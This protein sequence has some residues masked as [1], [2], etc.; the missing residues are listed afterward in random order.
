MLKINDYFWGWKEREHSLKEPHLSGP[1]NCVKRETAF[2]QMFRFLSITFDGLKFDNLRWL[3]SFLTAVLFGCCCLFR[4]I[5]VHNHENETTH[6]MRRNEKTNNK[7]KHM[8]PYY[9]LIHSHNRNIKYPQVS[10]PLH[11]DKRYSGLPSDICADHEYSQIML[12]FCE[13]L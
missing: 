13:I 7:K 11:T 9:H 12:K 10:R 2:A 3:V 8:I 6:G 5:V 1:S 4:L